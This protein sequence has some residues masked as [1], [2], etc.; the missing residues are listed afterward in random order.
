MVQPFKIVVLDL[1]ISRSVN[2][3][4]LQ[5]E[6]KHAETEYMVH[7]VMSD[8]VEDFSDLKTILRGE[9]ETKEKKNLDFTVNI[10]YSQLLTRA[11]FLFSLI[12]FTIPVLND[13][14]VLA[15]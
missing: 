15:D 13:G 3:I 2:M 8:C 14:C 10:L 11:F 12:K 4:L 5:C 6:L 9:K 7:V 1:N